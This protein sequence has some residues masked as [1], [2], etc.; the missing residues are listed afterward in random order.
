MVSPDGE[1]IRII[2]T[3]ADVT[4]ARNA[5]ERLLQ[6]ALHDNLTGLP[7][8]ELFFD[9]LERALILARADPSLRPTLIAIDLD[10]FR[11]VNQSL[12]MG[13][14]RLDLADP[15]AAAE[16]TDQNGGHA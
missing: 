6:D 7:N 3:L 8:R 10:K 1:V 13:G 14:R 2:G 5:E 15:C 11:R 9:R 16:P 4:E 12:G